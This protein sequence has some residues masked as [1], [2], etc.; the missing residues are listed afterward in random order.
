LFPTNVY[1][2]EFKEAKGGAL[3]ASSDKGV[4][5][6]GEDGELAHP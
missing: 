1:G 5:A 6:V 3:A 4:G 2:E